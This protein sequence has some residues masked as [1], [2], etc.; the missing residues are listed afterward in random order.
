ME[1]IQRRLRAEWALLRS[2]SKNVDAIERSATELEAMQKQLF[3]LA[4]DP[5]H[6]SVASD[7]KR[8]AHSC[9]GVVRRA[10]PHQRAGRPVGTH[11]LRLQFEAGVTWQAARWISHLAG[12]KLLYDAEEARIMVDRQGGVSVT[13]TLIFWRTAETLKA[14]GARRPRPIPVCAHA[15]VKPLHDRLQRE[16]AAAGPR[17]Q[18]LLARRKVLQRQREALDAIGQRF[19]RFKAA[20]A[21]ISRALEAEL[22]P[23]W[24]ILTAGRLEISGAVPSAKSHQLLVKLEAPPGRELSMRVQ[25]VPP[26]P[27][28]DPQTLPAWRPGRGR[29]TIHAHG[30][31]GDQLQAMLASPRRAVLV[32]YGRG[33]EITGK[34]AARSRG[35]ALASL[36]RAYPALAKDAT[37]PRR[38]RGTRV[39]LSFQ[40]VQACELLRL[41]GRVGRVRVVA[42]ARLPLL[43][44]K[45]M[46]VPWDAVVRAIAARGG[47]KVTRR[48][49]VWYLLP[50][51]AAIPARPDESK[52]PKCKPVFVRWKILH[53]Q[54]L[55]A[56][57]VGP[58]RAM[59]LFEDPGGGIPRWL[60]SGWQRPRASEMVKIEQGKVTVT[61]L[62]GPGERRLPPPPQVYVFRKKK[63]L[64]VGP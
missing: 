41:L 60:K 3:T 43:T 59:A 40:K 37:V 25:V 58:R 28:V 10:V 14:L 27:V 21:I 38:G 30:A 6:K 1:E 29:F 62:I 19:K 32:R 64:A 56:T 31:D 16:L 26:P 15:D 9:G 53:R 35:A 42:G 33:I 54:R 24:I 57:I 46:N 23:G 4:T 55:T 36:L 51:G 17:V 61:T 13:M 11:A 20:A 50:P 63:P 8:Q 2:I 39:D 48:P 12:A 7:V 44:V 45:L 22:T 34:V 5:D 18:R 47:L 49:G 52:E